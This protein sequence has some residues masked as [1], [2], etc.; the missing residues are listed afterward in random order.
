MRTNVLTDGTHSSRGFLTSYIDTF[1]LI[2]FLVLS[3]QG[4]IVYSVFVPVAEVMS[5]WLVGGVFCGS[6]RW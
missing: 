6:Q 5:Y 4:Y 2:F 3:Q 1:P